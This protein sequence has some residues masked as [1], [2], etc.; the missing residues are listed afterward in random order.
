MTTSADP[1]ALAKIPRVGFALGRGDK[2]STLGPEA[3]PVDAGENRH[4]FRRA[5]GGPV[6]ALELEE[7]IDELNRRSRER[8]FIVCWPWY[9]AVQDMPEN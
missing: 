3:A 5:R 2:E 4:S 7:R 6:L 9:V 8:V 1:G